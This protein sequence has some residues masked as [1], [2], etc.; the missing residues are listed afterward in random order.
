MVFRTFEN[1][2]YG[3]I[4]EAVSPIHIYDAVKNL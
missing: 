3:L 2:S 4:M 1:I